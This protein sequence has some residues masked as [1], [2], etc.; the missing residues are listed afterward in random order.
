MYLQSIKSVKRN[1]AKSVKRAILK[2][3]RHLL[4]GSSSLLFIR[5]WTLPTGTGAEGSPHTQTH[6]GNL[7]SRLEVDEEI[8]LEYWS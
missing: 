6:K 4:E 8:E 3:S 7:E 2:K 5:P 1:A